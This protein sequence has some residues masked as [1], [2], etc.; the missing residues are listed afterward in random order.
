MK[1]EFVAQNSH[2]T[3]VRE[4]P[5]P[6]TSFIPDWY[7]K[8]PLY[9]NNTQ[10][11]DL[12]PHPNSTVKKCFPVLDAIGAGYIMPLWADLLVTRDENDL[13][14][15]K[16]NTHETVLETW[17]ERQVSSYDLPNNTDKIVFKYMHGWQIKTPKNW[18][19]LITQPIGYTN[20]PFTFLTGVVDTDKLITEINAPFVVKK[21]FEG[22]VE[23][24]TPMFQIIPIK[25]EDWKAEYS[26]KPANQHYFDV[27]KFNTKIK[28]HYGKILREKK[29]YQ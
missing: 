21:G 18:S 28:S 26:E 29:N 25:R 4:K 12:S 2:V 10:T 19:V 7:K 23:K 27:E 24:G 1:I 3:Q 15:I 5:L 17:S 14:Y 20:N 11:F 9:S 13:P 6:A 8:I 16:W 22:I